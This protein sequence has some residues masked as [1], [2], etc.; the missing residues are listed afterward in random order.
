MSDKKNVK[1]KY[2]KKLL[3]GG[4]VVEKSEPRC[5]RQINNNNNNFEDLK[6]TS[7]G[8]PN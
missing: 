3:K 4:R 5:A 8:L 6:T 7:L 2:Q 1:L